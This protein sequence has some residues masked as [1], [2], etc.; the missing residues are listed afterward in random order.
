[1]VRR[2]AAS[3][4]SGLAQPV[5]HVFA[6]TAQDDRWSSCA[7][8]YSMPVWMPI[9]QT[10]T[11]FGCGLRSC[12]RPPL[13]GSCFCCTSSL[14]ASYPFTGNVQ[15]DA[16]TRPCPR[17]RN[18]HPFRIDPWKAKRS[19]RAQQQTQKTLTCAC[20]LAPSPPSATFCWCESAA[21]R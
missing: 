10:L 21:P 2:R 9:L 18:H 8:R 6:G 12:L 3:C 17:K 4:T 19:A 11:P 1:M 16:E 15:Y 7:I 20:F 5:L 14:Y 13:Q